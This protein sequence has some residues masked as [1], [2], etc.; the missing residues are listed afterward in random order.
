[1]K[2]C[3]LYSIVMISGI[4]IQG[5]DYLTT[6][7][8]TTKATTTST[9][10]NHFIHK[11]SLLRS[12][13]ATMCQ[14]SINETLIIMRRAFMYQELCVNIANDVPK[15]TEKITEPIANN[16]F[17]HTSPRLHPVPAKALK[18]WQFVITSGSC[19]DYVKY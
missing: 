12:A 11:K 2:G 10:H 16:S 14:H 8:M 17:R 5:S 3:V 18:M 9:E 13:F 19:E 6:Q 4:N 7:F 1:M 15:Q